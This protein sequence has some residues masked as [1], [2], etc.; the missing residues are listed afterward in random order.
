MLREKLRI[1]GGLT[2]N[3]N[4]PVPMFEWGDWL[5]VETLGGEKVSIEPHVLLDEFD[6]ALWWSVELSDWS[7]Y[8]GRTLHGDARSP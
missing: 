6:S 7:S 3:A 2:W 1:S 4:A 8:A 5:R